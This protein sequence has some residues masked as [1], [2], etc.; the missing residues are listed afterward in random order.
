[1]SDI[2][3]LLQ[4]IAWHFGDH[5][6]NGECCGGLSFV[7]FTALKKMNENKEMSIQELGAALNFT[8][9]GATRVTNRLEDKGYI[10]RQRSPLD[11]RVCC[12]TVTAAGTDILKKITEKYIAYL[13]KMLKDMEPQ[14]ID[15]IKEVLALLVKS[16][17][18]QAPR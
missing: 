2:Y 16:V 1:M 17:Y 15:H 12:I 7:E 6:F 9:S 10:R 8:K 14:A 4:E 18:Q 5:E 11:G 3:D 13:E